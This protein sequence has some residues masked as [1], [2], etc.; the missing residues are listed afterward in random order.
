[1]AFERDPVSVLFDHHAAVALHNAARR[2]GRWVT[3]KVPIVKPR[4]SAG[5]LRQGIDLYADDGNGHGVNRTVRGFVRA[6]YHHHGTQQPLRLVWANGESTLAGWTIRIML[7]P[8]GS[9][10]L[11]APA[12][13]FTDPPASGTTADP[14]LRDW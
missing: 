7:A 5:L 11:P 12:A 14:A 13:A 3:V 10:Q 9:P 2:Q 6:L 4:V 8:A 1:M